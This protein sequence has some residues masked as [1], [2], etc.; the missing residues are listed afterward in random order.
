M[1]DLGKTSQHRIRGVDT[2]LVLAGIEV[3]FLLMAGTVLS[4]GFSVR[5]VLVTALDLYGKG[6]VEGTRDIV[7]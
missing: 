6:L 5:I 1:S 7:R 4:F 3:I 2:V